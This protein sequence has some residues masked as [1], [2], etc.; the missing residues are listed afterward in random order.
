DSYTGY[1]Y[2]YLGSYGACGGNISAYTYYTTNASNDCSSD[3]SIGIYATGGDGYT[4][5]NYSAY[6]TSTGT[7]YYGSGSN[8]GEIYGLTAGNYSIV[9]SDASNPGDG[10]STIISAT[11][12]SDG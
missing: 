12:G 9:V 11:I 2:V 5:Y 6:N 8:Y 1:T 10:F 3:G 7:V 4:S